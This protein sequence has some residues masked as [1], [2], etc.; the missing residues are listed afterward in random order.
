MHAHHQYVR[1]TAGSVHQCLEKL[2][3]AV[4]FGFIRATF[5]GFF[6]LH[7]YVTMLCFLHIASILQRL[8]LTKNMIHELYESES[9]QIRV[10][11]ASV[12]TQQDFLSMLGHPMHPCSLVAHKTIKPRLCCWLGVDKSVFAKC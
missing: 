7:G 9:Y 10:I 8:G 2:R 12:K 11:K 5:R 6:S 4:D 3:C 1:S